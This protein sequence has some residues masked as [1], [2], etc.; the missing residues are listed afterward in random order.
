MARTRTRGAAKPA[1]G[2]KPA[3]GR[4]PAAAKSS[5]K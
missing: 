1:A 5:K 2:R 4:K 3:G